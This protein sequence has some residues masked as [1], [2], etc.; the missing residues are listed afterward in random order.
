VRKRIVIPFIVLA[1]LIGI[2]LAFSLH[3]WREPVYQ[4]TP[5]KEWLPRYDSA[6]QAAQTDE[7]VRQMGAQ[8]LPFLLE[9]LDAADS[10]AK[11]AL[12]DIADEFDLRH[13]QYV[14]AQPQH[15]W[16]LAAFRSLGPAAA[17]AIPELLRLLRNEQTRRNAEIALG[18]VGSPAIA[19][20]TRAL[21]NSRP[22]VR[23]AAAVALGECVSPMPGVPRKS[24]DA[25]ESAAIASLA[26]TAWPALIR[27]L[28]DSDA[29]V[30][31]SAASALGDFGLEP[32]ATVSALTHALNDPDWRVR[33]TAAVAVGRFRD[34]AQP[35]VPALV[36]MM[37]ETN[38]TARHGA[39]FALRM[40][41]PETASQAGGK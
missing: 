5:L 3:R 8:S 38:A 17:P 7:A 14:P 4:G 21:G 6:S 22:K 28:G 18:S 27:C 15:R 26:A 29:E 30:R 35:A 40:I 31:A 9:M 37:G 20:L 1:A 12:A 39:A 33:Y 41:D 13:F 23:A 36:R 24:R 25:R 2:Q 32:A 19:P 34:A 11:E 16:A 10:P